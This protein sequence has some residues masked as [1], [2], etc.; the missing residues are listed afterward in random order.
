MVYAQFPE[1]ELSK[2][3]FSKLET[4]NLFSPNIEISKAEKSKFDLSYTETPVLGN[5]EFG[6]KFGVWNSGFWYSIKRD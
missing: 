3:F 4:P 5:T 1:S 2:T 6:T